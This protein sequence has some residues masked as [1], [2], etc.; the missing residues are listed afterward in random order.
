[1]ARLAADHPDHHEYAGLGIGLNP[2]VEDVLRD[3][4][5]TLNLL[6]AA[7]ASLAI[8]APARRAAT[9]APA[10]VLRSE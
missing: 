4:R 9:T 1:M 5:P 7:V 3:L 2:L 6:L 10:D 8:D